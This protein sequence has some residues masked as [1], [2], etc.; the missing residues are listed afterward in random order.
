RY[1]LAIAPERVADF[2]ALCARERAPWAQLGTATADGR[3]VVADRERAAVDVP[4]EMILG[5]PPRMTRR[6]ERVEPEGAPLDLRGATIAEA[7]DRVLGLPAVADKTFLVAIGDRTVGGMVSRDS[8][9]GPYQVPVADCAITLAGF[10][11][12]AG[13]VMAL[14]E[15]PPIALL[16]AAAAS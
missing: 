3:L 4:L 13:E 14:G 1:V 15:R 9:V 2:A 11:S 8:M 12:Y 10:D 16:D 5:K 6:A 7:L